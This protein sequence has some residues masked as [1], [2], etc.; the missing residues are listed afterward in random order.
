MAVHVL[1]NFWKAYKEDAVVNV[2]ILID[3]ERVLVKN[4]IRNSKIKDA[5]KITMKL[6]SL[7]MSQIKFE[8]SVMLKSPCGECHKRSDN[9]D[10]LKKLL[11][12]V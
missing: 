8:F 2:K 10:W 7:K 4:D 3:G 1:K 9:E 11:K 5:W 12:N 6:F